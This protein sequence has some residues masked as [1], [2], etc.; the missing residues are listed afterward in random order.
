MKKAAKSPGAFR[1]LNE[2]TKNVPIDSIQ[3]HPRN[4]NEAPSG[5]LAESIRANGWYGSVI[6]QRSTGHILAGSHRW[7]EAKQAGALEI[8]ATFI[9]VD[10][11][12]AIKIMLADNRSTRLGSDG[13][14]LV[15]QGGLV[16]AEG[17]RGGQHATALLAA[18]A[19]AAT[20]ASDTCGHTLLPASIVCAVLVSGRPLKSGVMS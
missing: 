13:A 10:D 5:P 1:V 4:V 9:S 17:R 6:V 2:S 15:D 11:E 19:F 18:R 14:G 20:S 12:H 16:V 8:P 3:P 7:K